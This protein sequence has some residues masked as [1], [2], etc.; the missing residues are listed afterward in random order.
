MTFQ[1]LFQSTKK[2]LNQIVLLLSMDYDVA[3]RLEKIES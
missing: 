2:I 1:F 3:Y